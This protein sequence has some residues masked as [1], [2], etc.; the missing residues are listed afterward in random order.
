[1]EIE[2]SVTGDPKPQGSKRAFH[3]K[4]GGIALVEMAGK[5]L[6]DW[7]QTVTQTAMLAMQQNDWRTATGPVGVTVEFRIRR[8]KKPTYA[9]PPRPDV[10]KM[11]RALLDALTYAGVWKDDS[12]VMAVTALKTYSDDPG[13][14]VIVWTI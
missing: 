2:F 14:T 3:T 1:M 9:Y 7:R 6:K 8:P 11:Q 12:Q 10:D 4:A 13:A 5:P